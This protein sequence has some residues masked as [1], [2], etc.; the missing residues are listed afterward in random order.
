MTREQFRDLAGQVDTD[1][2]VPRDVSLVLDLSEAS[3]STFSADDVRD[4]ANNPLFSRGGARAVVAPDS[5]LYG[6]VRMF[7]VYRGF[8]SDLPQVRIFRT[9]AEATEWLAEMRRT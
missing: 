1:P 7:D 6:I 8:R 4:F 9:T 5:T 2:T 3:P